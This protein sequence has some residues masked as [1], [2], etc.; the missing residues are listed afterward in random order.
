MVI[1]KNHLGF[2]FREMHNKKLALVETW[3]MYSPIFDDGKQNSAYT[4]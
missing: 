3:Q 1:N 2:V 4:K